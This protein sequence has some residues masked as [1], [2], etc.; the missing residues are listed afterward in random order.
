MFMEPRTLLL[1]KHAETQLTPEV[2]AE[3]W[4]LTD[5]GR[6]QSRLLAERLRSYAPAIIVAS[7]EP[8]AIETGQLVAAHLKIPLDTELGL[9]EHDRSNVPLVARE[10]FEAHMKAFFADPHALVYGNETAYEAHR[11]FSLAVTKVL[12]ENPAGT[13]GIV[14]H[15]TVMALLL[16]G[17]NQRDVFEFWRSLTTPCVV[18]VDTG[19]WRIQTLITDIAA[20]S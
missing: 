11:R 4:T 7:A 20:R 14:A 2:T 5:R 12:R 10:E 8:K 17:P 16:A 3:R 19:S 15:G 6:A 18:V 1:I 9:H 13:I